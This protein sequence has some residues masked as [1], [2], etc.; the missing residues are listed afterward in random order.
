MVAVTKGVM[1]FCV[2]S[3]LCVRFAP[4]AL[5]FSDINA[6]SPF[7]QAA[8]YLRD[9]GI[10]QGYADGSFRP[11]KDVNRAEFVKIVAGASLKSEDVSGCTWINSFKDVPS[12]V[13][14]E[15]YLCAAFQSGIIRGYEDGTFHGEA[16]VNM[17]EAS[18][19]IARSFSLLV[20][21]D[22]NVWY[23]GSVAAVAAAE[24]LPPTIKSPSNNVRRAEMAYMIAQVLRAGYAPPTGNAP[25]NSQ[26]PSALPVNDI[27][28]SA[29]AGSEPEMTSLDVYAPT[30]AQDLPVVVWVHGG[31]WTEG[32]KSGIA[33]RPHFPEFFLRQGYILVSIN[34]RLMRDER[35]PETTYRE[36]AEDVAA[37]VAWTRKNIAKYGGSPDD[38]FLLGHSA[39][40]HLVSLVGV[41]EQY[42]LQ[43][44]ESLL[45][46]KGVVALDVV[47]YDI[48][49]AIDTAAE[50]GYP[51]SEKNLPTFFPGE[52]A[53]VDA[54]P[55]LHIRDGAP[56]PP[57]LI[58]YAE[59]KNGANGAK[60]SQQLGADQS[61]RFAAALRAAGAQAQSFYGEGQTHIA[62][63]AEL[64][65]PG[66]A[67]TDALVTFLGCNTQKERPE[68]EARL[69]SRCL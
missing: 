2:I 69:P 20:Q 6:G 33:Q 45:S 57:F 63:I 48:P 50:L 53:Q 1:P 35:S 12:G 8:E 17:A 24:A 38:V 54:S 67:V 37:A 28:Y 16:T 14:Y 18:T 25:Q 30:G 36:Q 42:L 39:G 27:V 62:L 68:A 58:V 21:E 65:E 51:P 44:G 22:P 55:V 32:D 5:A 41:N 15:P 13:W 26:L 31:G 23:R 49:R 59:Y 61:D 66:H 43:A 64:G 52:A 11:G 60:V 47:A 29:H 34:Y 40:A 10:V 46:L 56:Y 9:H 19:I 7:G 3:L 4:V